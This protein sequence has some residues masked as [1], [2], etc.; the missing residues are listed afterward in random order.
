MNGETENFLFSLLRTVFVTT[1]D[2]TEIF[3]SQAVRHVRVLGR[4]ENGERAA[5]KAVQYGEPVAPGV[6]RRS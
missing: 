4:F 3:P 2:K 1:I 6:F 5:E